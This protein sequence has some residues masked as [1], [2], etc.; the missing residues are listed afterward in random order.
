MKHTT[1]TNN[2]PPLVPNPMATFAILGEGL[3]QEGQEIV[4]KNL[5]LMQQLLLNRETRA[6][7][8]RGECDRDGNFYEGR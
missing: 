7:W 2:T 5:S 4:M 8:E 1:T 6:A 3:N